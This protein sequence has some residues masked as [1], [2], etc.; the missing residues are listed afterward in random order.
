MAHTKENDLI[1]AFYHAS[2]RLQKQILNDYQHQASS[3]HKRNNLLTFLE[4][5]FMHELTIRRNS[6]IKNPSHISEQRVSL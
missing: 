5:Q 2:P 3:T 6:S 1:L 4:E